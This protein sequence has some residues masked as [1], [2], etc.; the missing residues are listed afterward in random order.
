MKRRA[1]PFRYRTPPPRSLATS[2]AGRL[3]TTRRTFRGCLG[4]GRGRTRCPQCVRSRSQATA[5]AMRITVGAAD[6]GAVPR[7]RTRTLDLEETP[8]HNGHGMS[9]AGTQA[10]LHE[11]GGYSRLARAWWG[12][13]GAPR[14][15]AQFRS[16]G[17]AI[18]SNP[19]TPTRISKEKLGHQL[20]E[21]RRASGRSEGVPVREGRGRALAR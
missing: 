6:S 1:S 13:P 17:K 7:K 5:T 19:C 15:F 12:R 11:A 2:I 9:R 14:C 3:M 8:M 21:E 10:P 20:D 18:M 4:A 16:G